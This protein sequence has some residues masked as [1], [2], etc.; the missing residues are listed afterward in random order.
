ISLLSVVLVFCLASGMSGGTVCG[1][2][3]LR[4]GVMAFLLGAISYGTLMVLVPRLL[5][6]PPAAAMRGGLIGPEELIPRIRMLIDSLSIPYGADDPMTRGG[7]L[8][9]GGLCLLCAA[10]VQAVQIRDQPIS[11]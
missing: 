1:R 11:V 6:T 10:L 7:Y 4:E 9:F 3:G 2:L 8:W 5:G